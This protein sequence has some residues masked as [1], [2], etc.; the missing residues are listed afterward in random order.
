MATKQLAAAP[1]GHEKVLKTIVVI[2]GGTSP[3]ANAVNVTHSRSYAYFREFTQP[4]I[5]EET[6]GISRSSR[7]QRI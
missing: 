4:I 2:V 6:V 7:T 3:V 5:L 1:V